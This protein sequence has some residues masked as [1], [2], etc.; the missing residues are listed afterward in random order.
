LSK[1]GNQIS[2]SCFKLFVE[3]AKVEGKCWSWLG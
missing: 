3:G 1:L 2:K